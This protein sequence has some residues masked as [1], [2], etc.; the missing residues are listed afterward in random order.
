MVLSVFI[1]VHPWLKKCSK[2]VK[3]NVDDPLAFWDIVATHGNNRTTTLKKM[4]TKTLLMSAVALLAAGI[5]ST[6]KAQVYS[7]NVVGYASVATPGNGAINYLLAVPFAIGVSNGAN[8]IFGSSLP[9]FSTILIWN[10]GKQGY[11]TVQAFSGSSTGWADPSFATIPAPILPVGQGFFLNPA[12]PVTNTFAGTVIVNVGTSNVMS[13]PGNG[14]VN[15]LVG[16][17]VPYA[18]SVT[19]GNNS[20]GGPNLNGLPDFSTV[21]IWNTAGQGYSTVQSF[22]GSPTGWADPSFAPVPPPTLSVG[23]GFFINPSGPYNWITGL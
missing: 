17:Y 12:S 11:T 22:S 5:V 20:T 19:N 4:R 6:T 2:K 18:G 21:L 13:L 16:C 1:R 3:K 23:Q 9:D 15:F 14:A 8:E 7:Q 10:V